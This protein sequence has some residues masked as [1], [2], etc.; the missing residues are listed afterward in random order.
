MQAI[1]QMVAIAHQGIE[2]IP[3]HIITLKSIVLRFTDVFPP[4]IEHKPLH[5]LTLIVDKEIVD[6]NGVHLQKEDYAILEN[7]PVSVAHNPSSNLKLG[8]GIANLKALKAH[9]K[10]LNYSKPMNQT[11]TRI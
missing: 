8:S 7:K 5:R 3:G 6:I 11:Q 2:E 4:E 1:L 10:D 9:K